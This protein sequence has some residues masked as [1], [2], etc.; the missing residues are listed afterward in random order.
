MH[1]A[2][3]INRTLTHRTLRCLRPEK[4]VLL[5]TVRLFPFRSLENKPNNRLENRKEGVAGI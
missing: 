1:V 2:L 5:M 4:S 3:I